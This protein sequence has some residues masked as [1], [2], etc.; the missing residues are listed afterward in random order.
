MT[1]HVPV[2]PYGTV[3]PRSKCSKPKEGELKARGGRQEQQ[4]PRRDG[5]RVQDTQVNPN[6]Q[7]QPWRWFLSSKL[8]RAF[9]GSALRWIEVISYTGFLFVF[10]FLS[11]VTEECVSISWN[12]YMNV[13]NT[14]K[15][16][17]F[18]GQTEIEMAWF[19][20]LIGS[21]VVCPHSFKKKTDSPQTSQTYPQRCFCVPRNT[22]SKNPDFVSPGL[23][24][25]SLGVLFT[26]HE[27]SEDR[28][29]SEEGRSSNQ[30]N[31]AAYSH[32]ATQGTIWCW[33]C[34]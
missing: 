9:F 10:C 3:L 32:P 11:S 20:L 34:K 25:V 19:F 31:F 12:F 14:F 29:G 7:T 13:Y 28:E 1:F 17:H 15:N 4:G 16:S 24:F 5:Q 27:L 6:S 21:Q 26:S 8:T 23:P 2:S 22:V 18:R 30:V 33:D